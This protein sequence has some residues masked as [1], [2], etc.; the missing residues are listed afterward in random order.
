VAA[1]DAEVWYHTN[2]GLA[3]GAR[4]PLAGK[5]SYAR[6]L[7]WFTSPQILHVVHLRLLLVCQHHVLRGLDVLCQVWQVHGSAVMPWFYNMKPGPYLETGK[8]NGTRLADISPAKLLA[9]TRGV[10]LPGGTSVKA[11]LRMVWYHMALKAAQKASTAASLTV[12][13][14]HHHSHNRLQVSAGALRAHA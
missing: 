3:A 5:S 11:V 13:P 2:A 6:A 9:Y 1:H 4:R 7:L 14:S 8:N 10:L 12:R